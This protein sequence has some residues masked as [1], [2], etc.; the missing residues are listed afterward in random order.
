MIFDEE[1]DYDEHL[2]V[3]DMLWGELVF[4][5]WNSTVSKICQVFSQKEKV[6]CYSLDRV[7]EMYPS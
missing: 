6:K 4:F 1:W 3:S 2:F 7:Y 5:N